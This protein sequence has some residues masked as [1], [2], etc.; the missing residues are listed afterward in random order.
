MVVCDNKVTIQS[1]KSSLN[2]NPNEV[3]GCDRNYDGQHIIER[4][5]DRT[6]PPLFAEK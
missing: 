4:I 6:V 5:Y 3:T 2:N 1:S